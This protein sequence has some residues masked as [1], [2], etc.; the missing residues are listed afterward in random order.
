MNTCLITGAARRLG[1]YLALGF[2]QKGWNIILHYNESNPK[3]VVDEIKKIGVEVFPIK[4]DLQKPDEIIQGF[5][6]IKQRFYLPNVLINNAAVFPDR[7]SILDTS[8]E[9]WNSVMKINLSSVFLTSKEFAKFAD[10]GSRIINIASEGAHKI[11]KERISYNVSKSALITLTKAFARE[12]APRVSVNS[13]SP[14]YI[15]F[16]DDK[17]DL[18]IPKEMIPMQRY[19]TAADIF[20]VVY[21]LATST[22]YLTGQDII[23]DGGLGLF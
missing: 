12:L 18:L 16:E 2:A 7:K 4:F 11:W 13:I 14:G 19:S 8:I 6:L 3:Y 1:K 15:Q 5:N 22:E 17:Q 21:F 9:D 23:V 10:N 20:Q